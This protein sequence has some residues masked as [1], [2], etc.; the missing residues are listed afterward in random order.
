MRFFSKFILISAVFLLSSSGI[1]RA[2][3]SDPAA[4][5]SCWENANQKAIARDSALD[6][7]Y[8][9]YSGGKSGIAKYAGSIFLTGTRSDQAIVMF[10]GFPSVPA[11]LGDLAL[12]LNRRFGY[13]VYIPLLSGFGTSA[14]AGRFV[15]LNDWRTDIEG[16]V[17]LMSVCAPKVSIVAHSMGGGLSIDYLLRREKNLIPGTLPQLGSIY[18]LCP[19]VQPRATWGRWVSAILRGFGKESLFGVSLKLVKQLFRMVDAIKEEANSSVKIS[20]P[21]Y[22]TVLGH[23]AAVNSDKAIQFAQFHMNIVGQEVYDPKS[24]VDHNTIITRENPNL[25]ALVDQIAGFISPLSH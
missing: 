24:K 11:H 15:T 7:A 19:M 23:D 6:A 13:T 16:A 5:R 3:N 14:T 17:E 9:K 22:L 4:L 12:Q 8:R 1:T 21:A 20:L 2:D 10:H 18:L 25:P